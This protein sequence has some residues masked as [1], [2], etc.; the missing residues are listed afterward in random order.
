ML[1]KNL[2]KTCKMF[3]VFF[4]ISFFCLFLFSFLFKPS[5]RQHV[6]DTAWPQEVPFFVT[7]EVEGGPGGSG[8]RVVRYK[9]EKRK[10]ERMENILAYRSDSCHSFLFYPII[11]ISDNV[12]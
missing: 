1:L 4:S 11:L 10:R 3:F 8:G 6:P 5:F 12:T 7:G 9:R 2:K